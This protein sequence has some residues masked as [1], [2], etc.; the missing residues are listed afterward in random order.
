MRVFAFF[1]L[2]IG[3]L[4]LP[5]AV[6][7]LL[8]VLS[9]FPYERVGPA[10]TL[11]A[12]EARA[13]AASF[14][15]G[16]SATALDAV[17]AVPCRS[18]TRAQWPD[19][20]AVGVAVLNDA[21]QANAA[22]EALF[23]SDG[24]DFTSRTNA[25]QYAAGS[26]RRSNGDPVQIFAWTEGAWLLWLEAPDEARLR[27][28]VEQSS[29]L[30]V[31][32]QEPLGS[33]L[34]GADFPYTVAL[35]L[36]WLV[37]LVPAWTRTASWAA[38]V[39]PDRG[40]PAV[41]DAELRRRLLALRDARHPFE[42]REDGPWLLVTWKLE[43]QWLQIMSAGGVRL[44]HRL[45]LRIDPDDHTVRVRDE[46]GQLHWSTGTLGSA[47]EISWSAS[48]GITFFEYQFSAHPAFTV[49]RGQIVF[50]PDLH[51]RF[52]LSELKDPVL[53]IVCGSGWTWR[54]VLAFW[55]RALFG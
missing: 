38:V 24:W 14:A 10:A 49:E 47:P 29:F 23:R 44:V 30:R 4:L 40:I 32:A 45:R 20:T 7:V 41:A 1:A 48:R 17:G 42:I 27:G 16:G 19:S 37:C 8:L 5:G 2:A 18:G 3:G 12:P 35:Y 11:D 33:R 13:L 26:G 53:R 21:D 52:R 31:R 46:Q 28:R 25:I 9:P 54:P 39:A 6:L 51:Y 36:V 15:P 43:Q 22:L 55:N 34:L 50:K